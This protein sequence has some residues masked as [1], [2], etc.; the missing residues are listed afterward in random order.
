MPIRCPVWQISV[1]GGS[2]QGRSG[3]SRRAETSGD[4]CLD[5]RH[6]ERTGEGGR[7]KFFFG[8]E[9]GFS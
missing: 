6:G 4:D 3:R 5:P 1:A 8:L 7:T 9:D 2:Q